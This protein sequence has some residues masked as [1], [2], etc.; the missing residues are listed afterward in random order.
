MLFFVSVYVSKGWR[1]LLQLF[2]HIV[3]KTLEHLV[4]LRGV[5]Y[6]INMLLI[7]SSIFLEF[8]L[9]SFFFSSH[10]L[11]NTHFLSLRTY[12]NCIDQPQRRFLSVHNQGCCCCC[13]CWLECFAPFWRGNN[14][15]WLH[16]LWMFSV[17][18]LFMR[19]PLV[20]YGLKFVFA[21]CSLPAHCHKIHT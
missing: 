16:N 2:H 14:M 18:I 11:F 13:C 8:F 19:L 1:A 3:G 7:W 9:S 4:P 12:Y 17:V 5:I 21:I 15:R 10:K 20:A 6:K